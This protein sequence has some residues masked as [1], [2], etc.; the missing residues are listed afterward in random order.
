MKKLTSSVAIIIL[1]VT[2]IMFGN[3]ING[4]P[5]AINGIGPVF[6]LIDLPL[7]GLFVGLLIASRYRTERDEKWFFVSCILEKSSNTRFVVFATENSLKNT[8]EMKPCLEDPN[9]AIQI[10]ELL[11]NGE[12]HLRK[13]LG[14]KVL[15]E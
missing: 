1:V 9:P 5:F 8:K 12:R 14:E 3:F 11:P 13:D 6:L 10:F 7:I 4:S 15:N 2:F